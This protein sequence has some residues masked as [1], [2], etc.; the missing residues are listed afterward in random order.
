MNTE[1]AAAA[2]GPRRAWR[3]TGEYIRRYGYRILVGLALTALFALHAA[4]IVEIPI[5]NQLELMAYDMRLRLTLPGGVDRRIVIVDIDE[6][7]LA[8]EGRW[9]WSR[10]RIA[11]MV[12]N[13]F[14]RYGARSVGFDIVFAEP[15]RLERIDQ[16]LSA[17][18]AAGRDDVRQFVDALG[19]HPDE[20]FARSLAGRD[21]VLGYYFSHG[22]AGDGRSGML[23][24]PLLPVEIAEFLD[25]PAI[26]ANGYGANL[27]L[28]QAAA[29][30]GGFF[31]NPLND[32]DGVFRRIPL[33]QE[34]EGAL[35]TSLAVAM[36]EVSLEAPVEF[37]DA[38]DALRIGAHEVPVDQD[39]AALVPYRGTQG[40][41]P[42]VS[43]ADVLAGKSPADVLEG[44][45]VLVG[46]TAP[47][48]FDLRNTPV[49]KIYPG[50][51]I[52]ANVLSGILDDR[53]MSRPDYTVAL[54]M[55]QIIL[56]GVLLSF[57]LPTLGP[58]R[59]TAVTLVFL[60]GVTG[61]NVYMWVYQS[62]VVP[63]SAA[64][65]LI[66]LHYVYVTSY[67]FI[68]ESRNKK[69]IVTQFG[70][71]VPEAIVEEMS[72]NPE[73][74]SLEGQRR[75]L[76]VMFSDIRGFTRLSERL[77]PQEVTR[78]MNAYLS[79]MTEIIHGNQGT[80]DKYIGDAIMAF[81]GA[82]LDDP[83]H[84]SHAVAAAMAMRDALPAIQ[85]EFS[86]RGWPEIRIG[87]GLNTGVMAVGN[88][89]SDFRTSYTVMGDAVN[90]A[91]RVE[92]LTKLYGTP[93]IV[94]EFTAAAAPG[95]RYRKLD[96]VKVRGRDEPFDILEAI[97]PV[98]QVAAHLEEEIGLF[99]AMLE[100]YRGQRFDDAL[101]HLDSLDRQFGAKPLHDTF[102]TRIDEY[103][104]NP[105]RSDWLGTFNLD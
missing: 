87:I 43:A 95:I 105:P 3:A 33:V 8:V 6:K 62:A 44:A 47:G 64:L 86:A 13:L 84:A 96:R 66:A 102:R 5:V 19:P 103:R 60:L 22:G 53:F 38:N 21:V 35:Y 85:E 4:K 90:V 2:G 31:D 24:E 11:E 10:A 17:A 49:Q 81:W 74:Y 37:T 59:G 29:R 71:Y 18:E 50:V 40:S 75:E 16:L 93:L 42:Y 89:G 7:S 15:E 79:R 100:F 48:L 1:S 9:P 69:A 52:H 101:K 57:I 94:T 51:E 61:L 78:L 70:R 83:G 63:V 58:N 72:R 45:M 65:L 82:P 91:S 30:A 27:G 26:R 32:V 25:V 99:E 36:A 55:L 14:E 88:M 46:T 41:F 98:E 34:F 67:G 12:D 56:I 77:E 39:M 97:A 73:N 54:E 20:E 28:L 104:R 23:P 80:I 76:T 92:A 68:I